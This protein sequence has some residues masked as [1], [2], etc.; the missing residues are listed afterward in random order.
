MWCRFCL[1]RESLVTDGPTTVC[2][3]CLLRL[4][5]AVRRPWTLPMTERAA[6]LVLHRDVVSLDGD[7]WAWTETWPTDDATLVGNM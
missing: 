1:R 7:T 3:V 4:G 2:Y 6:L 5:E